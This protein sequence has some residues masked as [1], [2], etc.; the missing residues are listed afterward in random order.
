MTNGNRN[1]REE[2]LQV[3]LRP[4]EIRAIDDFRFA[5]RMPSRAAA[6]RE[7]LRL[8]LKLAPGATADPGMRS[9]DF[10]LLEPEEA[11]RDD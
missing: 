11:S 3:M 5:K 4:E 9:Q 8:A 6:I 10:G 1:T 2:R 7:L